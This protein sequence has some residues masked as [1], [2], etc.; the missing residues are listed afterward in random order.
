M[1]ACQSCLQSGKQKSCRGPNQGSGVGGGDRHIVSV[2]KFPGE[3][4][5]VRW[6]II[7]MQQPVVLSPKFMAKSSH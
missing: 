2:Q 3:N 7:I 5:S 1:A 6:C 4:G